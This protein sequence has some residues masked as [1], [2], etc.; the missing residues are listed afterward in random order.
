MSLSTGPL[1]RHGP[2][3][4]S[5]DILGG[6]AVSPPRGTNPS[7]SPDPEA[8][9]QVMIDRAANRPLLPPPLARGQWGTSATLAY[10]SGFLDPTG[11]LPVRRQAGQ[12]RHRGVHPDDDDDVVDVSGRKR[13]DGVEGMDLRTPPAAAS[14][15]SRR[16]SLRRRVT[17]PNQWHQRVERGPQPSSPQAS[18]AYSCASPYKRDISHEHRHHLHPRG[19]FVVWVAST[20]VLRCSSP[21]QTDDQQTV[22][23][24]RVLVGR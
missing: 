3:S 12:G 24:R 23:P 4:S 2:S 7:P 14:T 1:A 6:A 16:P 22:V 5:S 18:D 11:R 21:P 17:R 10:A 20:G 19:L 8:W 9:P 15:P 13:R